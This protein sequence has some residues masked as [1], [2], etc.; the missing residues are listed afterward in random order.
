MSRHQ[1]SVLSQ[2]LP[3]ISFGLHLSD[4]AGDFQIRHVNWL[5]KLN[6]TPAKTKETIN[7]IHHYAG[8]L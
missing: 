1:R 4:T 3:P 5:D 6:Q 2:I 7:H 8:V